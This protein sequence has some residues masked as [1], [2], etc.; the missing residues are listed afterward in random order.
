MKN[1]LKLFD[2]V[3]TS[4]LLYGCESWSLR[5]D[6]HRRLHVLQRKML[7]MV[8]NARRHTVHS[9]TSGAS[10]SAEA[11][12]H[13]SDASYLEPWSDFLRRT[14]QWTDQQLKD[15]GLSQWTVQAKRRKWK[16]AAQLMDNAANKWSAI[17]TQWQ[18]LLHSS[19]PRC[20]RPARPK[21]RWEQDLVDYI[22]K[23]LP[24]SGSFWQDAARDKNWWL[25]ETERFANE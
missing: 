17:A 10:V 21:K 24:E 20:R 6:Q 19:H 14:A 12:D 1:R 8:L 15:A 5:V 23:V 7:R 3:V 2:A 25:G 9:S 11:A 13:E 4:T 18:P 22:K 16:W